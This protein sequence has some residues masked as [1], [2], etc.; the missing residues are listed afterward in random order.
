MRGVIDLHP[1]EGFWA[2]E[3][4]PR[5]TALAVLAEVLSLVA[6]T[7]M[8]S[9]SSLTLVPGNLRLSFSLW[10]IQHTHGAHTYVQGRHSYT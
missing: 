4:A 7:H 9:Q 8:G 2:G 5:V 10:D 6:S 3:K 1:K